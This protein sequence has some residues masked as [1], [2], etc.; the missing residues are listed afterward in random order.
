MKHDIPKGWK[1]LVGPY[2]FPYLWFKST[3]IKTFIQ[4]SDIF[5]IGRKRTP[6]ALKKD[7]QKILIKLGSGFASYVLES[8]K[9]ELQNLIL[10]VEQFINQDNNDFYT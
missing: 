9:Q 7:N 2:W 4:F 5:Y 1:K 3:G 10:F 8:D 6:I